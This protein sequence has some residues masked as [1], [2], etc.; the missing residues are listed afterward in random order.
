MASPT[1][2]NTGNDRPVARIDVINAED[3]TVER[4]QLNRILSSL[5]QRIDAIPTSGSGGG[6]S[7]GVGTV[8]AN[9]SQISVIVT[10]DDYYL[11]FVDSGVTTNILADSAVSTAKIA[12]NAVTFAKIQ[13][14]ATDRLV[15]RDTAGTGNIEEI[16]LNSTLEFS[17]SGSIQRAALSGDITAT[18]GS[19]TTTLATVNANVGSFGTASSVG[20]FTVNAKGLI[21]AASNTT[22]SI[23]ASSISDSTAVGRNFITLTNPS[24]ITFIRVNADNS[25]SALSASDFRSAINL[26]TIAVQNANNVDIDGGSIDGTAIGNTVQAAGAFT[27]VSA[28]A[29]TTAALLAVRNSTAGTDRYSRVSVGNDAAADIFEIYA[30]SS[31]YTENAWAKQNGIALL[32]L[33]AGGMSIGTSSGDLRIFAGGLSTPAGVWTASNLAVAGFISITDGVT[34]PSAT[35]GQAKIYVNSSNGDLEVIFG[36]GTVKTI[37]TDT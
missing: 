24:A 2:I 14:V 25:V 19:N 4:Q 9:P 10:G 18:A 20:T 16:S 28:T 11:E 35:S 15:G 29:N 34:A 33:G 12:N 8:S 21:T 31:T 26:G 23:P 7:S 1:K 30:L 36:D 6:S 13:T 17:G 37:V 27:T 3:R 32:G 5:S 22:I